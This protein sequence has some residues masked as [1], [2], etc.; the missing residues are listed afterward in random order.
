MLTTGMKTTFCKNPTELKF[1]SMNFPTAK[2]PPGVCLVSH[3]S[4]RT[5]ECVYTLAHAHIHTFH[6][7]FQQKLRGEKKRFV[8]FWT[9]TVSTSACLGKFDKDDLFCLLSPLW[10]FFFS[11]QTQKFREKSFLRVLA[12]KCTHA[13]RSQGASGTVANSRDRS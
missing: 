13:V 3:L 12:D 4:T 11:S 1:C 8:S 6:S 10:F 9:F 5:R 7:C 2:S